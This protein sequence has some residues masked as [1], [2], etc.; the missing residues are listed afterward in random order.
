MY[1]RAGCRVL[2]PA[3][4]CRTSSCVVAHDTPW[5]SLEPWSRLRIRPCEVVRDRVDRGM[6]AVLRVGCRTD[7]RI[8]LGVLG[9]HPTADEERDEREDADR[10]DRHRHHAAA[11]QSAD[12]CRIAPRRRH[13]RARERPEPDA[14]EEDHPIPALEQPGYQK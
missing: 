8:A 9:D 6:S 10:G 3:S 5:D 13:A 12:L 14:Q 11:W 1:R 2:R 7:S 4:W